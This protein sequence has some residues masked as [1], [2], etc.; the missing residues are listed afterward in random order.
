MVRLSESFGGAEEPYKQNVGL[1]PSAGKYGHAHHAKDK[2]PTKS[3][4]GRNVSS[5]GESNAYKDYKKKKPYHFAS[6][7]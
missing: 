6:G 5:E 7:E 2:S 3:F 1:Y 4:Y